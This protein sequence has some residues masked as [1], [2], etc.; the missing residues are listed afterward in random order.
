MTHSLHGG[1]VFHKLL[2]VGVKAVFHFE[3]CSGL[4]DAMVACIHTMD[5]VSGFTNGV[6]LWKWCKMVASYYKDGVLPV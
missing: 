5:P 2:Q 4:W 3:P 6:T 1:Y